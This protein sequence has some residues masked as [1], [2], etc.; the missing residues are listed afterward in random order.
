M[1]FTNSWSSCLN[2]IGPLDSN[3]IKIANNGANQERRP[4]ITINEKMI[5]KR[6]NIFIVGSF[7][8]VSSR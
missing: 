1:V 3:L 7:K 5:K 8:R 4:I 6:F 2:K